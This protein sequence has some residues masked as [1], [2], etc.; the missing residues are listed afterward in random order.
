MWVLGST[1]KGTIGRGRRDQ[2]SFIKNNV[3]NT[4]FL[5]V[6]VSAFEI[7]R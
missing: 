5:R 7:C 3:Q 2:G 1:V 6:S 4:E